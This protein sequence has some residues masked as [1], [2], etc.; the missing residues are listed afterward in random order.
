MASASSSFV[1]REEY[2]AK[3]ALEE[4]RKAG[5]AS[6][7]VDEEGREINPHMPQYITQAPCKLHLYL[8]FFSFNAYV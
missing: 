5:T 3:K 7:A 8:L 4:A 1:S 6:A 2:R